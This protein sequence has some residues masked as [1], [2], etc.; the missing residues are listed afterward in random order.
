MSHTAIR[1]LAT[2]T[3][4]PLGMAARQVLDEFDA[5]RRLTWWLLALVAEMD[6][7]RT[8]GGLPRPYT[9]TWTNRAQPINPGGRL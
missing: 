4:D 6:R 8:T 9:H 7:R 1:L 3:G 5:Q 2:R